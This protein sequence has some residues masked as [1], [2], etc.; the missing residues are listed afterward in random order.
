[1]AGSKGEAL[2]EGLDRISPWR[3]NLPACTP[4]QLK[5]KLDLLDSL[6]VERLAARHIGYYW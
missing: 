6:R 5:D 1:M 2:S 4:P 3:L